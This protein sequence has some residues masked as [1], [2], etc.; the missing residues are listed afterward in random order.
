MITVTGHLAELVPYALNEP[1]QNTNGIP[2]QARIARYVNI[3]FNACAIRA[4]APSFFD[5]IVFGIAQY[6]AVDQFPGRIADPFDVAVESG[7][8]KP[9]I[10]DTEAA[11]PSQCVRI[12]DVK[13]KLL[14]G[15]VEKDFYDCAAQHL[16]GAYPVCTAFFIIFVAILAGWRYPVYYRK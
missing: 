15:E 12:N 8:L 9:H 13:G 6:V 3:A 1:G 14:I 5:T 7:F 16:L 2:Q 10:C 11:E 4:H